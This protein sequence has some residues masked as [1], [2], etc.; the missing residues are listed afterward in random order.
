MRACV[1]A[2]GEGLRAGRSLA[3][4]SL[5]ILLDLGM[6]HLEEVLRWLSDRTHCIPRLLRADASPGSPS[7]EQ[8]YLGLELGPP[9]SV[10]WPL[11]L[12]Q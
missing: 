11:S 2:L 7:K 5:V 6:L 8:V 12:A 3:P 4:C 9:A 10:A 1:C